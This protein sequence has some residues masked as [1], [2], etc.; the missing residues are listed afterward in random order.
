MHRVRRNL[1][2]SLIL[3]V[4]QWNAQVPEQ[5]ANP[6]NN[7]HHHQHWS[8]D[9]LERPF[10][11]NQGSSIEMLRRILNHLFIMVSMQSLCFCPHARYSTNTPYPSLSH[12]ITPMAH[13]GSP[14]G[15]LL[16]LAAR[17]GGSVPWLLGRGDGERERRPLAPHSL[18]T[19]TMGSPVPDS[20]RALENH[21]GEGWHGSLG[22]PMCKPVSWC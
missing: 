2:G 11:D 20:W 7:I 19:L 21:F 15:A 9:F 5:A 10:C 1:Q 4:V 18:A 16:A 14:A 17:S 6:T 13:H 3:G 12:P 8:C 22:D